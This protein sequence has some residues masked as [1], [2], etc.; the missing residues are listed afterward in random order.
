MFFVQLGCVRLWQGV[1][2]TD[3][4]PVGEVLAGPVQT[5]TAVLARFAFAFKGLF[6]RIAPKRRCR[7]SSPT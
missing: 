2:N 4:I 5:A 1:L 3:V 7:G 6:L